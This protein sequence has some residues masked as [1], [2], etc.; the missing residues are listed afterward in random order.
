MMTVE[1][2]VG[3]I[4]GQCSRIIFSIKDQKNSLPAKSS[5]SS[6]FWSSTFRHEETKEEHGQ[7]LAVT[8]GKSAHQVPLLPHIK[9]NCEYVDLQN[10]KFY[11]T[12]RMSH[13]QPG[14]LGAG[15]EAPGG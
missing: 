10:H 6:N 8:S 15:W 2:A 3:G 5:Q 13:R 11:K 14:N 12:F 9:C 1:P 4:T 7:A